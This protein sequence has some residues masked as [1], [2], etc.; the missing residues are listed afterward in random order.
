MFRRIR[1][2]A[3]CAILAFAT[4]ATLLG[5]T[6]I[7]GQPAAAAKEGRE[8]D[9]RWGHEFV[10]RSQMDPTC[11]AFDDGTP[12]YSIGPN[13]WAVCIASNNRGNEDMET[14]LKGVFPFGPQ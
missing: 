9:M 4:A 13:R 7:P 10:R 12:F 3:I 5:V 8:N 11:L 2:R 1:A 6:A 14:Y